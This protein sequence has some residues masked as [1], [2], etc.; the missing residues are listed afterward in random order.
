MT[1]ATQF[2]EKKP[3][4]RIT[5]D[6]FNGVPS[7]AL[8]TASP[9]RPILMTLPKWRIIEQNWTAIEAFCMKHRDFKTAS[10]VRIPETAEGREKMRLDLLRKLEALGAVAV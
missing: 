5:E 9:N 10:E 8:P 2:P 4:T 1:K 7:L 6:T 3:I